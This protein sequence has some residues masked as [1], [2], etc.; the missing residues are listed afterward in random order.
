MADFTLKYLLPFVF[1]A[2]FLVLVVIGTLAGP[3]WRARRGGAP[4]ALGRLFRLAARR[5][6]LRPVVDANIMA[7]AAGLAVPLRDIETHAAAGGRVERAMLAAVAASK[8][9]I[10]FSFTMARAMDLSGRDPVEVVSDLVRAKQE[11][12]RAETRHAMADDVARAVGE[13]GLVTVAVGAPG[14]V[15][16]NGRSFRAVCEDGYI[17]K[18]STVRI[19]SVQGNVAI[20]ER[21]GDARETRP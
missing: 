11:G 2:A 9:G 6:K 12:L 7:T 15:N 5:I 21:V 19:V 8:A 18:G 14:V 3:W 13:Q 20:V 4:V 1:I 17:T 10:E 16:V